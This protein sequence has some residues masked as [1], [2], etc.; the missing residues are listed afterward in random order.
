MI[1]DFSLVV[2]AS[3]HT[4]SHFVR[5]ASATQHFVRFASATQHFVRFTSAFVRFASATPHFVRFASATPH[6]VRFASATPHF[7]RFAS[8]TH[9][10]MRHSPHHFPF[11]KAT[12]IT[13]KL[14]SGDFCKGK[15]MWLIAYA[16]KKHRP[17]SS[18]V[19]KTD[20]FKC[21]TRGSN[22]GHPD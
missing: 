14:V 17:R 5:F 4:S 6:F 12:G 21:A 9:S 19:F 2:P 10:V 20:T 8:L 22:P 16:Q 18:Y 13:S 11:A 7:V 15:C 1:F 3:H